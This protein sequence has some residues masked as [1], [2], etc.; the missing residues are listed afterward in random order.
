[1]VLTVEPGLYFPT[2]RNGRPFTGIGVRIED[3]V[4]VTE[5]GGEVLTA[6]LPTRPN[7]ISALVGASA[8]ASARVKRRGRAG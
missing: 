7:E 3:D 8:R 4:L 1:M 2:T 5:M 6:A